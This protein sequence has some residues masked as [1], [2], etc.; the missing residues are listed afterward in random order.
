MAY[1]ILW[2]NNVFWQAF[3]CE[4]HI[5]F[6]L[7]ISSLLNKLLYYTWFYNLNQIVSWTRIL[8]S[9][10][11]KLVS[12]H[13]TLSSQYEINDKTYNLFMV[14]FFILFYI[15]MFLFNYFRFEWFT[16]SCST[17]SRIECY[18]RLKATQKFLQ[19]KVC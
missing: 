10:F 4:D 7:P 15:L 11:F 5:S 19:N 12:I 13:D 17:T 1:A 8:I 2:K 16:R 9:R 18:G 14:R 3:F 6:P